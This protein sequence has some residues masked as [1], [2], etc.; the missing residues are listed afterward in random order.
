MHWLLKKWG[1]PA[2]PPAPDS[3]AFVDGYVLSLGHDALV[4]RTDDL[5]GVHQLLD[6]VRAPSDD[7]RGGEQ[8]GVELLGDAQHAVDETAVEIHVGTD[9][10]EGVLLGFYESGGDLLDGRVQLEVVVPSLGYR[11]LLNEG[12]EDDRPG[13]GNGVHCVPH[14]VDQTGLVEDLLVQDPGQVRPE[15]VLVIQVLH[16][17]LDVGDHVHDLDVGTSVL[18]ALQRGKR[19]GHD[20]IRVGTG[21]GDH[22]G[23]EGGVVPSA[24]LHMEYERDVQHLG[25]QSRVLAVRPEHPEDVLRSGQAVVRTVDVEAVVAVVVAV[26]LV[27]VDGQHGEHADQPHALLQD[28]LDGAVGHVGVVGRQ[29]EDA[30]G[31][32]VHDVLAVGLHDHVPDECGGELPVL[33]EHIPEVIK[34]LCGG[35]ISEQEEVRRLLVAEPAVGTALY[36]LHDVV[37]SVPETALAGGPDAVDVDETVDSGYVRQTGEDA[38]PVTAFAFLL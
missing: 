20:G 7:P 27:A 38:F 10:G 34:L 15:L 1:V 2:R 22:T 32:R 29:S 21:G 8:R 16:V 9:P 17:R 33:G 30:L 28:V 3:L 23:G 24:V 35:E 13:I 12:F 14:A 11:Q 4:R 5:A 31:Y 37:A 25:L 18:W 36:H 26:G 19:R 6:P